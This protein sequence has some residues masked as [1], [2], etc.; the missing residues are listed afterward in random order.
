MRGQQSHP[1]CF[2]FLE[3]AAPRRM[4]SSPIAIYV[5]IEGGGRM[6]VEKKLTAIIVNYNN[7]ATLGLTVESLLAQSGRPAQV[8]VVDCGSRNTPWRDAAWTRA[9]GVEVIM[10]GANLGFTG[11]NNLGWSH[12]DSAAEWV[13]FLNPDVLLPTGI[14]ELLQERGQRTE[15]VEFA[16]ISPRLAG[17][18][19][20]MSCPTGYVDSSGVF[21]CWSGWADRRDVL[22]QRDELEEVPALCGAFMLGRIAA[23]RQVAR[24]AGG[25]FDERY[26]AY[27]EDV[28][29]SL[30]LRRAGWR[31]GVWHGGEVFHGRGWQSRKKMSRFV[32]RLSARNEVRLH[33][34]YAPARL[35]L[36]LVKWLLVSLFNR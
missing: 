20:G 36:S 1:A 18:D 14:I 27:K 9:D 28:E 17:Y 31:L 16:L 32:R 33:A 4:V 34:T 12:V 29:L 2:C 25:I 7:E 13:L 26:F 21:P 11:G 22:P 24:A 19:F 3:A 5:G 8:I 35:P 6:G 23:L 30:R 15:A 10:A